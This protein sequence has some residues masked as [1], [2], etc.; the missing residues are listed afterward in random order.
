MRC[1]PRSPRMPTSCGLRPTTTTAAASHRS[2]VATHAG[3]RIEVATTYSITVDGEPFDAGLIVDNQGRVYY[4]GLPTRDFASAVDLVKKVID[5]FPDDFGPGDHDHDHDHEATS[6]STSTA[7]AT[8]GRRPTQRRH[9]RGRPKVLRR[10]DPGAQSRPAR[11]DHDR[12]RHPRPGPPALHLRPVHRLAPPGHGPPDTPHP[13]RPERSAQRPRVPALAP[14][15]AHAVRAAA[16][17]GARR[18]HGR[19]ALLG[20]GCRW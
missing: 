10:R 18:R 15:D 20:L 13:T 19:P 5:Q 8:D 14:P 2:R 17:A 9:R 4:H 16:A 7:R 11:H 6:T 1:A 3:R 12:R